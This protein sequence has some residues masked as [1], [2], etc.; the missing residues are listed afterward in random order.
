MITFFG[1]RFL[2]FSIKFLQQ[3]LQ[4]Q[5]QLPQ[6]LLKPKE[7]IDMAPS[8]SSTGKGK[9]I[10]SSSVPDSGHHGEMEETDT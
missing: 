8:A 7:S 9:D 1:S 3:I 5:L 10:A 2:F 6:K 4:S